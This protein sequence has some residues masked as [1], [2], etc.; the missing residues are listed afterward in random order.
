MTTQSNKRNGRLDSIKFFLIIL[1]AFGHLIESPNRGE[2]GTA[3]YSMIYAFHM[4]LFVLLSGYFTNVTDIQ[5][6]HKRT[7]ML[8]ETYVVVMGLQFLY[9]RGIGQ[10]FVGENSGWYLISLVTWSYIAF[11][12]SKLKITP[13]NL[14]IVSIVISYIC[15]GFGLGKYEVLFSYMRTTQFLP[16]FICGY[17]TTVP[18][19][20]IN[21]E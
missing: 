10:L 17:I 4:P 14:L 9:F 8:V 18:F 19:K 2:V 11:G 15:F 6:L 5:K 20:L 12:L 7:L 21:T 1:V 13:P 16:F 3:L